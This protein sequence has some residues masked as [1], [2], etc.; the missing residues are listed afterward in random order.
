MI[1]KEVGKP[2]PALIQLQIVVAQE[3]GRLEVTRDGTPKELRGRV[4]R[5]QPGRAAEQIND[6]Y[7]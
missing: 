6:T 7:R 2:S 4:A 3:D 5:R 1:S